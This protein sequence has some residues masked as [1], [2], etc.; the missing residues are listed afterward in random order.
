MS[1]QRGEADSA[2][3][4]LLAEEVKG[5]LE[6]LSALSGF[7]LSLFD[8]GGRFLYG[9]SG[10]GRT[11][12]AGQ[13][14]GQARPAARSRKVVLPAHVPAGA[15]SKDGS[16]VTQEVRLQ[17][18]RVAEVRGVLHRSAD[19][20]ALRRCLR[21]AAEWIAGRIR[22]QSD[23]DSLSGEILNKYEELALLYALGDKMGSLFDTGEICRIVLNKALSVIGARKASLLLLDPAARRLRLAAWA[24][25]IALGGSGAPAEVL[26]DAD[27]GVW[28]HV[29]KTGRALVVE[30]VAD[31]P[32]ALSPEDE[33]EGTELFLPVPLILSPLKV[34][35]NVLG[36]LS[37]ADRPGRNAYQAGE[38]KLLSAVSAQAALA[39]HNSLLVRELQENERIRKEMEIAGE[40]QENLLPRRSPRLDGVDLAGR[41]VSAKRLGGDA[42]DFFEMPDGKLGVVVADVSGHSVGSAILMSFVRGV[43]RTEALRTRSPAKLL[44]AVNR[45]LY[46]DLCASEQFLTMSYFTY[47]AR[48]SLLTYS[49]AGHPPAVLLKGERRAGPVLIQA[50]GMAIGLV[51][52]ADF[53]ERQIRFHPGDVLA[54]YTDGVLD[55]RDT[56]GE[57]FGLDRFVSAL[58]KARGRWSAEIL[59]SVFDSVRMHLAGPDPWA[60]QQDDATVVIFQASGRKGRKRIS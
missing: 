40:I 17:E 14:M 13:A 36:I 48:K 19:P 8:G 25:S 59:E 22:A 29:V 56:R 55:A 31:L 46:E 30:D 51:P 4:I 24:G 3:E 26:I 28:G 60:R 43:L 33:P 49:C 58:G 21:I 6:E 47:D 27:K 35:E 32:E 39:I 45:L 20:S 34:K 37:L 18:E 1:W 9:F 16:L 15:C 5:F 42:Y 54:L 57:P 38:L 7:S 50:E 2:G 44:E 41:C 10:N 12:R 23:L 52:A 11:A 53:E